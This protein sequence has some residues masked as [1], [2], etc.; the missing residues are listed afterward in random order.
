MTVNEE[1]AEDT[2]WQSGQQQY[3]QMMEKLDV[4]RQN[5]IVDAR[6]NYRPLELALLVSVWC[7]RVPGLMIRHHA[8]RDLHAKQADVQIQA[9]GSWPMA[10]TQQHSQLVCKLSS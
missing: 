4:N 8:R 6:K 5:H 1:A 9:S 2:S 3:T 10:T 7:L